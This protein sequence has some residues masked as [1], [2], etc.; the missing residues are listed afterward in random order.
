V[1]CERRCQRNSEEH[2]NAE[3]KVDFVLS[4]LTLVTRSN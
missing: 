1:E 2:G 4:K 3:K